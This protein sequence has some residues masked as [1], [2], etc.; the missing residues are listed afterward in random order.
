V[1]VRQRPRRHIASPVSGR[2]WCRPR[3]RTCRTRSGA[4]V[5]LP[6]ACR[7]QSAAFGLGRVHP[8]LVCSSLHRFDFGGSLFCHRG[9]PWRQVGDEI[10]QRHDARVV[11]GGLDHLDPGRLTEFLPAGTVLRAGMTAT[12]LAATAMLAGAGGSAGSTSTGGLYAKV[13]VRC[14]PPAST[15]CRCR[16]HAASL[17]DRRRRVRNSRRRSAPQ[18]CCS[19]RDRLQN[20]L[21]SAPALRRYCRI[22]CRAQVP[23]GFFGFRSGSTPWDSRD[24]TC[25]R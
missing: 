10:I 4:H 9:T 16:R 8:V 7:G 24:R 20:G 22:G 3:R 6:V 11:R 23:S 15:S 25:L 17:L 14:S 19:W 18:P 13:G 1:Q 12:A 21:R 5:S 2:R